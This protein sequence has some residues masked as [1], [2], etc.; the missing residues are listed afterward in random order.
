MPPP[1]PSARQPDQLEPGSG[2][3]RL[4][5]AQLRQQLALGREVVPRGGQRGL[6]GLGGGRP[7]RLCLLILLLRPPLRRRLRLLHRS[8]L[9]LPGACCCCIGATSARLRRLHVQALLLG[10]AGLLGGERAPQECG[11]R[12]VVAWLVRQAAGPAAAGVI[13]HSRV[14]GGHPLL[15]L[16]I[17]PRLLLL[18]LLLQAGAAGRARARA[19]VLPGAGA[20][21]AP[22][23][24]H[25]RL[26]LLLLL[27]QILLLL[28]A[29][30]RLLLQMKTIILCCLAACLQQLLLAGPLQLYCLCRSLLPLLLL[31][32]LPL[33]LQLPQPPGR[34][35]QRGA[36]PG[37]VWR[38]RLQAIGGMA[39][40]ACSAP[41]Y[42]D[43]L[44]GKAA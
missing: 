38:L 23:L 8:S 41:M 9:L 18:L 20:G 32:L 40:S 37:R 30:L 43:G 21:A 12:A 35:L 27:R 42:L 7:T 22:G 11:L 34:L 28:V 2:L 29:L 25:V 17:A 16:L 39:A 13:I 15:V 19:V 33:Q 26:L 10:A 14:G 4:R 31:L 3:Q 1:L 5:G 24:L 6:G 44:E 36:Q